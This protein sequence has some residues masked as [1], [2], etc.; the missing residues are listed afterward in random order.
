M[1]LSEDG[2]GDQLIDDVPGAMAVLSNRGLAL[3]PGTV[4]GRA[5]IQGRGA[6]RVGS[7]I[8]VIGFVR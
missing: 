6:T 2:M 1:F 7:N 4:G 3:L 8:T 5:R